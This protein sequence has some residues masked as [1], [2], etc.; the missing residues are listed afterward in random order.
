MKKLVEISKLNDMLFLLK[1]VK[2]R[3]VLI[4]FFEKQ[5][6]EIDKKD[7]NGLKR[8]IYSM[9]TRYKKLG[10]IDK[11]REYYCLYQNLKN[12]KIRYDKAFDKFMEIE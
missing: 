6:M 7:I 3:K 1:T 8:V 2:S 10:D 12:G 11:S 4:E 9:M 5:I